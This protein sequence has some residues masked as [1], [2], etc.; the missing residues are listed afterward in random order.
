[1]SDWIKILVIKKGSF[2]KYLN[3]IKSLNAKNDFQNID[4]NIDSN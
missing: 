2:Y 3:E 1:M 4:Y